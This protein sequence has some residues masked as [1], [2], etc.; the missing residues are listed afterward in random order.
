MLD[1]SALVRVGHGATQACLRLRGPPPPGRCEIR[2]QALGNPGSSVEVGD[3]RHQRRELVLQPSGRR[4]G[5]R[6]SSP[7]RPP[8]LAWGGS[9]IESRWRPRWRSSSSRG[10]SGGDW[11]D[12][13]ARRVKGGP[14]VGT[15]VGVAS[16]SSE[17]GA[18]RLPHSYS[19]G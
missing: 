19:S 17:P 8:G 5:R 18:R 4:R 15:P 3:S 6:H 13:P 1:G 11:S 10:G 9:G 12:R 7:S 2:N 16:C 14:E